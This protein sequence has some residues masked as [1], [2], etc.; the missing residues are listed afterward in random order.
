MCWPHSQAPYLGPVVNIHEKHHARASV[1]A[2][3]KEYMLGNVCVKSVEY[4]CRYVLV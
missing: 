1:R 2:R 4:K 3:L